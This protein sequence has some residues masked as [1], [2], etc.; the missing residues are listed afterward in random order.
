M[1]NNLAKNR[2]PCVVSPASRLHTLRTLKA[3]FALAAAFLPGVVVAGQFT[4]NPVRIFMA[5]KDRTTSV[6]VVN[7]GTS[8][9]VMQ[10]DLYAWRQTASGQDELIPT[11]DLIAAPPIL[12]LAP[13]AKQV[14][15]MAMLKPM[16]ATEQL[17]YRVIIRE[18]PEVKPP[19]PGVQLQIALAFSLPIF[20]TPPGAKHQL[21]CDVQ[22]AAPNVAQAVCENKGTAYTQATQ[23]KFIDANGKTLLSSDSGGYILPGAKR[24]FE[25]KSA[26]SRFANGKAQLLVVQDDQSV[27]T[28]DAMLAE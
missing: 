1:T 24:S 23:F 17:T 5:T 3:T 12:K 11:D 21:V 27:L 14:V 22:R 28:F 8:D 26:T 10:A 4:V 18:I 9:L 6:T 19:E 2:K 15:R 7:E 25:L 20:I 13:G 16:S